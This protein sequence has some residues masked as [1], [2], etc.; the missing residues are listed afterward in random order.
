MHAL[1][2]G[3]GDFCGAGL[4]GGKLFGSGA[5]LFGG[6]PLLQL[7][8]A[9]LLGGEQRGQPH[10]LRQ[11]AGGLEFGQFGMKRGG[12]DGGG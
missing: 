4:R 6:K 11:M 10:G 9:D 3:D 5:A 2:G 8:A 12:I 7:D 1:P